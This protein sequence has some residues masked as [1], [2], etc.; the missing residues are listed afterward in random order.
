MTHLEKVLKVVPAIGQGDVGTVFAAQI[1]V[2][3]GKR[4]ANFDG[5]E[6]DS[7]ATALVNRRMAHSKVFDHGFSRKFWRIGASAGQQQNQKA[8]KE[9]SR[10]FHHNY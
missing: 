7:T 4:E 8:K 10:L 2:A 9:I 6:R 3:V 1:P 5:I